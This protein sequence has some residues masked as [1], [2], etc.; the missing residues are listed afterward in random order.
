V[1]AY[2]EPGRVVITPGE[3]QRDLIVV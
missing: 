1:N 2:L 3:Y